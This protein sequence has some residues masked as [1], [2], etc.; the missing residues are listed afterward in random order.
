MAR[1]VGVGRPVGATAVVARAFT[2]VGHRVS[3]TAGR[4]GVPTHTAARRRVVAGEIGAVVVQT[5][6]GLGVTVHAL[7]GIVLLCASRF[8]GAVLGPALLCVVLTCITVA[9]IVT[10]D[11][12]VRPPGVLVAI[13]GTV[14]RDPG[15]ARTDYCATGATAATAV[16]DATIIQGPVVAATVAEAP[17]VIAV[18]VVVAATTDHVVSSVLGVQ[19][20]G[21]VLHRTNIASLIV[22]G[23]PVVVRFG[24]QTIGLGGLRLGLLL[25]RAR[26]MLVLL[27]D[28]ALLL[29]LR[30]PL[31]CVPPELGRLGELLFVPALDCYRDEHDDQDH[32]DDRDDDLDDGIHGCLRSWGH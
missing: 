2:I 1:A 27:D 13:I 11:L 26:A 31:A 10:A 22:E 4:P 14:G 16:V 32:R 28:R 6:A 19:L 30:L 5:T 8:L 25:G 3:S 29:Q 15:G 20:V 12:A 24:T 17:S 18:A 7:P 9:E 23:G 21:P